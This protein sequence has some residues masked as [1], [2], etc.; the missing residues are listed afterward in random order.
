MKE[1]QVA[2]FAH[3]RSRIESKSDEALTS[4]L[5]SRL[6]S[7]SKFTRDSVRRWASGLQVISKP[8]QIKLAQA[9]SCSHETLSRYFKQETPQEEFFTLID[10]L[11][12]VAPTQTEA[13]RFDQAVTLVQGFSL[14]MLGRMFAVIGE[15]FAER[16]NEF[17]TSP[18]SPPP[19]T[20]FSSMVQDCLDE[21]IE[22]LEGGITEARLRAIALGEK[23][24]VHEVELL[25]TV[26]P[27]TLEE[28]E[29]LYRKEH[30]NGHRHGCQHPN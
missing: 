4:Y 23:P 17:A 11:E 30:E 29:E 28:L 24:T 18:S 12:P 16:W 26:L 10:T 27:A 15:L 6:P 9:L 2:L 14:P 19:Q 3:L 25:S 8:N 20:T 22:Q 21:C 5:N 1:Q 13:E 7:G